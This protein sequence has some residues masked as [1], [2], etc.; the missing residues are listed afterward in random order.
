MSQQEFKNENFMLTDLAGRGDDLS[1]RLMEFYRK[2]FDVD[3]D[4][5]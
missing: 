2:N 1:R 4:N 3:F 5:L